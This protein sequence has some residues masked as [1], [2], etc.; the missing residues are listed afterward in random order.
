MS[1]SFYD[2]HPKH[3]TGGQHVLKGWCAK[4][5]RADKVMQGDFVHDLRDRPV[6]L[7]NTDNDE[8]MRTR[9]MKL[10]ERFR[11][12]LGVE[13]GRELTW[14]VDR[15]MKNAHYTVLA[16]Q[17]GEERRQLGKLRVAQRQ[18][19]RDERRRA[20]AIARLAALP[21]PDAGRRR[22]LG[23]LK[24]GRTH[25][26]GARLARG[27][28]IQLSGKRRLLLNKIFLR[29]AEGGGRVLAEQ[30]HDE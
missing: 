21:D 30:P 26:R 10:V 27:Q 16:E 3:H 20:K 12:T 25:A 14:I 5:R 13:A 15:Q 19:A 18:A 4:I 24:A 29:E 28:K 17:R 8:D 6:Y 23:R 22:E 2:P 1:D 9:F 7:E 11:R